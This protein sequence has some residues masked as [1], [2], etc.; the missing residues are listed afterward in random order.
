[1][2]VSSKVKSV[3]ALCDKRQI[4]LAEHFG[5]TKQVMNNKM[6]RD[7]WSGKDL[8]KVAEFVGG[9]LA[10]I[11]PNGQQIIIDCEETEKGSDD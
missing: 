8:A 9:R 6:N 2:T 3:L 7:S 4:E 5:M 1:M 10:F 11:L